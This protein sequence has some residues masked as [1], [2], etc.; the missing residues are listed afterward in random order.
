MSYYIRANS[1]K[2]FTV[3][4]LGTALYS[5]L[6]SGWGKQQATAQLP[7]AAYTFDKTSFWSS[8]RTIYKNKVLKEYL[9]AELNC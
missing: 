1:Q 3:E 8:D 2:Q 7:D 4:Q 6:F 9:N 5:V